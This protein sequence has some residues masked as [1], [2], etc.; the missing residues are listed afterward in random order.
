MGRNLTLLGWVCGCACAW[1]LP[2]YPGF[3]VLAVRRLVRYGFPLTPACASLAGVSTCCMWGR[4]SLTSPGG[5]PCLVWRSFFDL[6]GCLSLLLP[7]GSAVCGGGLCGVCRG[8]VSPPSPFFL[9]GA[10]GVGSRPSRWG[11]FVS[12]GG[13]GGLSVWLSVLLCC[14]PLVVAV[15]CYGSGPLGP[16]PPP[17]TFFFCRRSFFCPRPRGRWPASSPAGVCAGA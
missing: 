10:V 15:A 2:S 12:C 17:L 9:A 3:P 4:W 7:W 6:G 11:R 14:G 8:R 13:G 1:G 16:R 5:L